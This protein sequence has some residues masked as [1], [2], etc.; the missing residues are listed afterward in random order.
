[1]IDVGHLVGPRELWVPGWATDTTTQWRCLPM[2]RGASFV[3]F[4]IIAGGG[5]GARQ[6][7]GNTT[8]GAGGGTSGVTFI[9]IPKTH[10]PAQIYAT[11]GAGGLGSTSSGVA[12]ATGTASY[13]SCVP[14]TNDE[15]VVIYANGGGGG[16]AGTAGAA[17]AIAVI[18]SMDMAT[19]GTWQAFAGQAGGAGT[20]LS[21]NDVNIAVSLFMSAG[22][23]GGGAGGASTGNFGG[24]QV[25]SSELYP[26]LVAP[27]PPG[28][29]GPDG[30]F[31][32]R[33]FLSI[34]G[35]GGGG[36]TASGG[37]VGGPGG[38]GGGY[39]SGGGGGG[40]GSTTSGNG[41]NGA[42]GLLIMR[43]W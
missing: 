31:I 24:D 39:G 33:P 3:Q 37:G 21:G 23:A 14:S 28:G 5:G 25:S 22:A 26:S 15:D 41:G 40:A 20:T 30:I 43:W 1:M 4:T 35:C 27:N 19:L 7:N 11:I 36:S 6:T 10:L 38:N 32:N 42:P 34:G 17:G 16:S 2:P 8:G 29:V 12:G 18:A 9:T 13:L